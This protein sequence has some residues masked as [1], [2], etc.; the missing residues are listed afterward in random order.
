[1]EKLHEFHV[2]AQE[3]RTM[4]AKTHNASHKEQLLELASRW[5]ALAHE[6]EKL[7]EAKK[8]LSDSAD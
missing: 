5:D 2:Q 8:R 3:C 7:L 6:R 4:A 1:M